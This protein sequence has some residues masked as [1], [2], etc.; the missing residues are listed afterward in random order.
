ME[1]RIQYATTNDGVSIAYA[2][3]GKGKPLI[4]ITAPGFSHTELS[5]QGWANVF[6]PLASSFRTAWYDARGTGLSDRVTALPTLVTVA[7]KV[8]GWP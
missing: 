8:T 2:E 7:V 1:P 4:A 6:P 3:A 5:W